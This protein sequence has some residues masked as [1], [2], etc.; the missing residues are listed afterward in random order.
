MSKFVFTW[1]TVLFVPGIVII[2]AGWPAP[3]LA[4]QTHGQPEGLMVHQ[5]A[6]IFFIVS[7]G[8][9]EFWLRKRN[10]VREKGWRL[11]QLS[12]ILF[13]LWNLDAIAVHFLDEQINLLQIEAMD[14]WRLRI[15]VA[16]DFTGLGVLYYLA[17]FDHLLC[18][19]AMFSLFYGLRTLHR[20][21]RA[22][23]YSGDG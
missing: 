20:E 17:K 10:L 4:T 21:A 8:I 5:L 6:H 18:V 23:E 22:T 12:A 1:R 14:I 7:M 9:L 19:P 2:L 3:A 16:D 15:T 13:L 11:I